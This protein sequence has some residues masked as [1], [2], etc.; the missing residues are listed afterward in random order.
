MTRR[1][2]LRRGG[3]PVAVPYERKGGRIV[4]D[5]GDRRFEAEV[6]REGLWFRVR[7]GESATRCAVARGRRQIWVS[8]EGR[9]YVLDEDRP[10]VAAEGAASTDEIRA[11]M[12]GRVVQVAAEKGASVREGDLLVTIEA[13]KM[14]FRVTAPED[15][16]VSEV[17]CGAGERVELGDLLVT[18]EPG[19]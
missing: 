8:C 3:T 19:A 12:T 16:V 15:G 13:M 10:E 11:P 7:S 18:L 6:K 4:L 5:L 9:T 1:L 14:E 2:A 17:R